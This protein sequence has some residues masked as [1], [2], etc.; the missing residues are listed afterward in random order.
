[1][2]H[3]K[4]SWN[5][6]DTNQNLNP[7]LRR[8]AWHCSCF[9]AWSSSASAWLID[10]WGTSSAS[11]AGSCLWAGWR[12]LYWLPWPLGSGGNQVSSF[13]QISPPPPPLFPPFFPPCFSPFLP[14]FFSTFVRHLFPLFYLFLWLCAYLVHQVEHRDCYTRYRKVSVLFSVYLVR[15]TG[16][17]LSV[18]SETL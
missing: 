18:T 5:G 8:L 16:T 1:V 3:T 4:R 6:S 14:P 7:L 10:G 9:C 2:N 13:F 11:P 17:A 12:Y 15:Q